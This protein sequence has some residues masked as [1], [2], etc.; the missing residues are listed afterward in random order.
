[1]KRSVFRALGG[2]TAIFGMLLVFQ[3][4]ALAGQDIVIKGTVSHSVA[5]NGDPLNNGAW[6]VGG[7][8][9]FPDSAENNSVTVSSGGKIDDTD[10]RV[11]GGAAYGASG[12]I[13]VTGNRVTVSG[14]VVPQIVVGGFASGNAS[15]VATNNGVTI[16][17]GLAKNVSGGYV[18][19]GATATVMGNTVTMSSGTINGEIY[20]GFAFTGI[21]TDGDE[22]RTGNPAAAD[23]TVAISGGKVSGH[24]YGGLAYSD[25]GTPK[26]TSNTVMLSGTPTFGTDS[27]LIGGHVIGKPGDVF[28]D[29]VLKIHNYTGAPVKRVLNFAS[30]DFLL[31]VS[32]EPLK[33]TERVYFEKSGNPAET[34]RVT[35]VNLMEGGTAPGVGDKIALIHATNGFRGVIAN[36]GQ[37]LSGTKGAL[38][39][40]FRLEQ[41]KNH[42]YAVVVSVV[43]ALP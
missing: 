35:A 4:G 7:F 27:A 16:S 30:Y 22:T 41:D 10:L 13:T 39:Y 32:L 43:P 6:P 38:K 20:G 9:H 25:I 8:S 29:N 31:P 33:V 23:N 24:V 36:N 28:T 34:A 1:M 3:T 40:T 12:T 2:A 15:A 17:G 19:S 21:G 26:A 18:I 11:Y 37:A 14:E 42:L 5:G